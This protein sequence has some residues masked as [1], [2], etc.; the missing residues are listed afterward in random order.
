MK[1]ANFAMKGMSWRT[2]FQVNRLSTQ[3]ASFTYIYNL[4]IY[5]FYWGF[6]PLPTL[7]QLSHGDSSVIHHP[8]VNKPVLGWKMCP[9][10][11]HST[12]TVVPRL[13]IEPGTPGF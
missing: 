4:F 2:E 11:G 3:I 12:M 10:K 5:L 7:F 1:F 8:W 13:G 6:T 9:A